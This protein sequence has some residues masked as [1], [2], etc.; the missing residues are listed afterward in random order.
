MISPPFSTIY[1]LSDSSDAGNE[2]TLRP[3]AEQR[4][5]IAE[6]AGIDGVEEFEAQIM[7]RR[8]SSNRFTYEATLKADVVQSCVVTL[9]PVHSHLDV[10]ITRALHLIRL[11]PAIAATHE[12]S[13]APDEGPEEIQDSH[14]DLAGPLLEDFA[15]AIDPYPR[16]PG[17]AFEPPADEGPPESPFAALK[18]F[19]GQ[20]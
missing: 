10:D 6:W 4:A 11:S 19:K 20:N 14:Y 18:G 16:C 8:Q 9:A 12:L 17:V 1:D 5:R 3:T 7:L 15:L 13:P 2:I